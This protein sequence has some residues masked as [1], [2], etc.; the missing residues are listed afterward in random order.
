MSTAGIHKITI[1]GNNQLGCGDSSYSQFIVLNKPLVGFNINNDSQCL[2]TQNFI[3][4]STS[5]TLNDVIRNQSFYINDTLKYQSNSI[6]GLTFGK[7][8][9]YTLKLK[10]TTAEN[11]IDS[12]EKTLT[13]LP[14]PVAIIVGD[15]VCLGEISRFEAISTAGNP[16]KNWDWN[17]GD[18]NTGS[19]KTTSCVFSAAGAYNVQLKVTDIFQCSNTFNSNGVQVVRTL[20]NPN[21]G[22]SVNDFGI[23]QSRISL[24]PTD[25]NAFQ[26]QWRF[27]NGNTSSKDTPSIVINDLLKGDI[28]LV[29][30]NQ[31]GCTDS[32]SQ[33]IYV[34]P[35]NFNVYIPSA[36]SINND[37]L[38][39]EFRPIGLGAYKD[40]N[41][42]IY[43][44]WG[45]QVFN[46]TDPEIGWD[47]KYMN[48]FVMEGV[49]TYYIQFTFVDGKIYRY[50]GTLNV[51]R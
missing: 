20:P 50:S 51:L 14:L 16:V 2:N 4:N 48:E 47:G 32:S 29:I 9:R 31:Y 38:N 35:N 39:D 46:S 36:M 40:Y 25:M 41:M 27:P 24:Q 13:V 30:T 3:I 33:Y 6:S 22:I 8:G 44:R 10:I 23:N 28:H 15:T 17:F 37:L 34:Y 43:N 5:T 19:G 1:K 7:D 49:Y 42:R 45:E 26:Y 21:F 11:C 12:L 18:G